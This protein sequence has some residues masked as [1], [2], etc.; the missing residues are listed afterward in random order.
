MEHVLNLS[1]ARRAGTQ[2]LPGLSLQLLLGLRSEFQ[3]TTAEICGLR[4]AYRELV[5]LILGNQ[6][7]GGRPAFV[8]E[9]DYDGKALVAFSKGVGKA[10]HRNGHRALV[11]DIDDQSISHRKHAALQYLTKFRSAIRQGRITRKC[12]VGNEY[13]A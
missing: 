9:A 8:K 6:P 2:T 11:V 4:R 13:S 3:K 7:V 10:V 12:E 1:K 5:N